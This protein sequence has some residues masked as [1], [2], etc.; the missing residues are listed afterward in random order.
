M[1]QKSDKLKNKVLKGMNLNCIQSMK[2]K[3]GVKVGQNGILEGGTPGSFTT[4]NHKFYITLLLN[5]SKQ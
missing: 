5:T 2:G 4:L 3:K 1:L